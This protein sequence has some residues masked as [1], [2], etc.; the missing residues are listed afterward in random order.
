MAMCMIC[1]RPMP[2]GQ[3]AHRSCLDRAARD[4]QEDFCGNKCRHPLNCDEDTL[5]EHCASCRLNQMAIL[6]KEALA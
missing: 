6:C 2:I 5:A 4:L 3:T 1:G